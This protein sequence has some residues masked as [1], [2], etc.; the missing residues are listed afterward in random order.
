MSESRGRILLV[1]DEEHILQT[2]SLALRKMGFEVHPFANPLEAAERARSTTFEMALIDLKMAPIDGLA[3]LAEVK[4]HQPLIT[5]IIITA[6]GTIDSAVAAVRGGA[7]DYLP[8]PFS[9]T[10]LQHLIEKAWE[11]NQLQH[12]VS[13]LRRQLATYEP[14]ALTESKNARMQNILRLTR[15]IADSNLAVLIEGESGTGKEVIARLLHGNSPRREKSFVTINCGAI[16]EHL[17]ESELFGHAKGAFTGA[18][19]DRAGKVESADGGTILFD[20]IAELPLQLQVKLLRFM[21]SF[22]FERIG[23]NRV[24]TVDVRV[25]TSTNRSLQEAIREGSFREDLFYRLN[26]IRLQLPPLRERMED[27]QDF[28]HFFLMRYSER[29]SL[30]YPT[31]PPETMLVLRQYRWPGNIRELEHVIERAVFLAKGGPVQTHHLPDE[32]VSAV[33]PSARYASLEEME[34]DYIA[35]LL[36]EVADYEKIA[37]ILGI[38]T[39]TLWRKRKKYGL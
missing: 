16:P 4:A 1:D 25:I 6:H 24:R 11:H 37:G 36:R 21:Q 7:Y 29:H 33:T 5:A 3:L 32:L 2:V 9:L 34:K 17:I 30:P 35:R 10:E 18:I 28:L 23:E 8:K 12:E 27:F 22:E 13:H 38:D 39:S 19:R 20:E 31:I 15:D 26:V 14:A